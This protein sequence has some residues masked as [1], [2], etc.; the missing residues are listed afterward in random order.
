MPRLPRI[1]RPLDEVDDPTTAMPT[2][3][4]TIGAAPTGPAPTAA[5]APAPATEDE[6]E[7]P[8]GEER[9]PG[10][11]SFAERA[12]LRRRLR[13]LRRARELALRDLGGL[14][15][16]LHRFGR[17][18]DDLVSAKLHTL[19][20]IAHEMTGLE[21]VLRERR[22]VTVL[23]EPGVLACPRCAAIYGE[24]T[25]YCPHC[26]LP[27]DRDSSMPIVSGAPPAA[28]QATH[29]M[30]AIGAAPPLRYGAPSDEQPG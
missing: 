10:Q 24:E 27:R 8:A 30:P 16:D 29:Q 2:A 25:N 9:D 20:V 28:D 15:F 7:T 12:R 22:H 1:G 4:P 19:G 11:L 17:R 18:R 6:L 5:P 21:A 3:E 14:V 13:F 26:G 23:H